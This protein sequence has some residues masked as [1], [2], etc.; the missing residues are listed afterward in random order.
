[1]ARHYLKTIFGALAIFIF[2]SPVSCLAVPTLTLEELQEQF[3]Q[4]RDNH[5]RKFT[6]SLCT[7]GYTEQNVSLSHKIFLSD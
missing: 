1:M 5:V 3:Q 2:A 7:V 4:L 6:V